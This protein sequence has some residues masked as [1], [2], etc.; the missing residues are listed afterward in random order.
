[1]PPGLAT[2]AQNYL[3]HKAGKKLDYEREPQGWWGNWVTEKVQGVSSFSTVSSLI[4]RLIFKGEGEG[5][6]L[7]K[8]S[9]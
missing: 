3:R 9:V 6:K 5:D 4:H 1:M 7:C 8:R 2:A